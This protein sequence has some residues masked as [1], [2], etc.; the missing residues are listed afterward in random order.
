MSDSAKRG[1][2]LYFGK[3][4]CSLC[5]VGA[6]LTDELFYNIGVGMTAAKPDVGRIAHSKA[7]AVPPLPEPRIAT[8]MHPR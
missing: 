2:E 6:N 1:Q 3:A 8:R 7:A 5:H 4:A